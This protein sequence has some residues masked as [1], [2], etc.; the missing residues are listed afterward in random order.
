MTTTTLALASGTT[1][2]W[3]VALAIGAVVI[4]VVIALLTLLLYF[5]NSIRAGAQQLLGVAGGVAGNTGNIKVALEVASSLDEVVEEAGRHA[6][7]LG[8]GAR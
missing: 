2:F 8:V 6:R 3:Q 4:I 1:T 5:V 7:L